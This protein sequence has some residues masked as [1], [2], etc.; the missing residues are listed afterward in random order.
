MLARSA[1]S[2]DRLCDR[3]RCEQFVGA[4][5]SVRWR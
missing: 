5:G 3:A 1:D 2:V 4:I